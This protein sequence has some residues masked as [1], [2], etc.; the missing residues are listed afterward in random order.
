[1]FSNF[2]KAFRQS[3]QDKVDS[4]NRLIA[5]SI[6]NR[7]CITCQNSVS[8]PYFEHG[9][10]SSISYCRTRQEYIHHYDNCLFYETHKQH[11]QKGLNMKYL[12]EKE[13][14]AR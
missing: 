14:I 3:E 12:K 5:N 8:L 2:K 4:Y 6:E 1:M 7:D 10:E 13:V 9:K 11:L